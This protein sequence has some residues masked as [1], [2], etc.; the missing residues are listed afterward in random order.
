MKAVYKK[1]FLTDLN[2]LPAQVK[3]KIQEIVFYQIPKAE[4]IREIRGIRKLSGYQEF[5]RLRYSD[6]RIGIS[7]KKD[8]MIFFRVM[9]RKDIYKYFP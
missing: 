8:R 2:N 6:Y 4:D 7:V 3:E 5:Y 1:R 9:H